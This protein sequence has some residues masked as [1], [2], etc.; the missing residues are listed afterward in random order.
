MIQPF[1]KLIDLALTFVIL[2]IV[3][4]IAIV[5]GILTLYITNNSAIAVIVTLITVGIEF[6]M[7]EYFVN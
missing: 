1:V 7:I 5:L 3:A 2:A 4:S 6:K